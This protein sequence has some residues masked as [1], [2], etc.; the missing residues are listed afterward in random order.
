MGSSTL[1][2]IIGS[3]IIGGL[4]LLVALR[5]NDKATTNTF[6]SQENLTAQQNLTSLINNIE[7]DFRKIGYT[8]NPINVPANDSMII[9]GDDH[10]IKFIAQLYSSGPIDTIEWRLGTDSNIC[11]NPHVKMLYRTVTDQF[12][13]STTYASNLGVTNFNLIYFGPGGI[14]DTIPTPFNRPTLAKLIEIDLR[15][16]PVAAYDTAYTYNFGAWRQIRFTSMNLTNR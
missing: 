6:Q 7:F 10:D 1:L 2:D 9:H 12:G 4:L 16:E 15:V 3:A 11:A 8:A 5:L 14:T 13:N